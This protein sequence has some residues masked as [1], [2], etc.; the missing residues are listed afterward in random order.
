MGHRSW[1]VETVELVEIVETVTIVE[2]F[3]AAH[4]DT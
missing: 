2:A 4:K 3:T 1:V